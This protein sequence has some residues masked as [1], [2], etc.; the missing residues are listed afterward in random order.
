MKLQKNQNSYLNQ[1]YASITYIE[2]QHGLNKDRDI[3]RSFEN[4]ETVTRLL[5]Y[6]PQFKP[7]NRIKE[8]FKVVHKGIQI[9]WID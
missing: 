9:S 5:D 6:I 7:E 8:I 1:Y 4:S 3:S 2:T